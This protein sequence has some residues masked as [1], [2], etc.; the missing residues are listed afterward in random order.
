MRLQ[1]AIE[2][3]V[4]IAIFLEAGSRELYTETVNEQNSGNGTETPLS[5]P[6]MN[7]DE[8]VLNAQ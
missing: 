1:A 6:R 5:H 8:A 7:G 4:P 2:C 3:P